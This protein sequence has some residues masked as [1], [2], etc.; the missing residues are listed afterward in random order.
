[1][2]ATATPPLDPGLVLVEQ[3]DRGAIHRLVLD[4]DLEGET[5][6]VDAGGVATTYGLTA[7]TPS[8]R[9]LKGI[10]VARAFTAHQHHQLVRRVVGEASG[11]TGLVVAPHVAALYE[12]ADAADAEIDRLFTAALDVLADLADALAVP[13]LVSA[14]TASEARE[15]AIRDRASE[16]IECRSTAL[17]Y[18][19]A[20][21][22]FETTGYWQHGWWQTTIPYWAELCG[23]CEPRG[24]GAVPDEHAGGPASE[25]VTVTEVPALD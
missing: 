22:S 15:T 23:V 14:P 2:T 25:Q 9:A 20:T 10:R 6:W 18:A 7:Q 3:P 1:M 5:L 19:F 8:R 11:R 24:V 17:G 21:E 13:V 4:A 16:E 12:R